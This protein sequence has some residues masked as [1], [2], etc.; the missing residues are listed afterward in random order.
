MQRKARDCR[1]KA[2]DLGKLDPSLKEEVNKNAATKFLDTKNKMP[3]E[4]APSERYESPA[5]L[6]GF[7]TEPWSNDEQKLLEQAL[8]TYPASTGDR[9]DR[10]AECIPNRSKKDCLK[11]YKECVEMVK[12]KQA[13]VN[14][15]SKNKKAVPVK[16]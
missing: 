9:W 3:E 6:Q 10:I 15:V 8:K 4:A 1:D 13:A 5:E 16:A 2:K 11:R 12:A 7:N 14:A